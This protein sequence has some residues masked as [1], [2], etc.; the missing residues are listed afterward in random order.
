[1][2]RTMKET[3]FTKLPIFK[4][5]TDSD[6]NAAMAC[7]GA[8]QKDFSKEE[9]VILAEDTVRCVG[10]ILEGRIDMVREDFWGNRTV[11]V[12]IGN[13]E[14]FGESFACGSNL[15]AS[16]SFVAREATRVLFLPF[17]RVMHT[18]PHACAHH[19]SLVTNM[20]S[21]MAEKNAA[22]ISKIDIMSKKTLR[23][24]IMSYLSIQA[25]CNDSAYFTVPFGRVRL[26]EYLNADRSA[27][28]RELNNLR[29]EG[30]I[31]F[32]KNTFR[33]IKNLN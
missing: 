9:F 32:D 30:I 15:V 16:V 27:L 19:H 12:S 5:M 22:F 18:C 6:I 8:F 17:D 28:T 1:M 33:I 10:V 20:V 3:D 7:V 25:D 24:K 14:L 13:S 29:E 26:A 2:R 31:D 23:E 21:L 4:G 11:L